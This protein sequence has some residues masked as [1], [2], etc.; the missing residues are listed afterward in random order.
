MT[1]YIALLRGINV[2]TAKQISMA[3]LAEVFAALGYP[4]AR[5]LLR[6]GN[7]VFGAEAAPSPDALETAIAERTGVS[8]R[9][10]VFEASELRAISR[11]NPLLAD[12]AD[13]SKLATT[14]LEAPVEVQAPEVAEP[15]RIVVT[16]RAVYQYSP[17]GLSK[18]SVPPAWWKKLGPAATARNQNTIDKLLALADGVA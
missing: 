9:V 1:A 17:L 3:E 12:A 2:G 4:G 14:L 6:S 13:L 15:E 11:A 10:L 5:T 8:A 18:S 7:V 16:D